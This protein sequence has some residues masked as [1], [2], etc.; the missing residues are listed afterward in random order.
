MSKPTIVDLIDSKWKTLFSGRVR[1]VPPNDHEPQLPKMVWNFE[2]T[3]LANK[4][5]I[6]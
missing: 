5:F 2:T 3:E 4:P 6:P 1:L